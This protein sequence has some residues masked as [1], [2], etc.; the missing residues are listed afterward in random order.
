MKTISESPNPQNT[1]FHFSSFNFFHFSVICFIL[2]LFLFS[3][4]S[5]K[6]LNLCCVWWQIGP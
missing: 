6:W 5:L 4:S 3:K 1:F 2:V